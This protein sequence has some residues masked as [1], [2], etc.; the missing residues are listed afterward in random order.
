MGAGTFSRIKNWVA[1]ETLTAAQLNAEFNNILNNLDPTGIDDESADDAAA[2][3][4]SDPYAGGSLVKATSLEKEIQQ[5]RYMIA[6]ITGETYWYVDPTFVY[7]SRSHFAWTG[8]TALSVGPGVYYCKDKYCYWNSA[9]AETVDTLTDGE[10]Y[11]VYLDYS[12]IT[13]GTAI[14]A[15]EIIH[16]TTEPAWNNTYK[17]WMNGDD[18]CIFGFLADGT[19]TMDEFYHDGD[20]VVYADMIAERSLGA[21][22]T[23]WTDVDCASSIPKFAT[24]ALCSFYAQYVGDSP[25]GYWRT[26]GQTATTGH[27]ISKVGAG[28]VESYNTSKVI[29]DSTQIIEIKHSAGAGDKMA[30]SVDGWFF[31]IGL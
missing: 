30:V 3:A 22:G 12:A 17:A 26:N 7:Y 24:S 27:A 16:S 11:Y 10:F 31:P 29:T 4:T 18:R 20:L 6:Q 5:L 8:A 13:S 1:G 28:T 21:L 2:Q 25:V 15:T 23:T 19:N 14:T 9:L